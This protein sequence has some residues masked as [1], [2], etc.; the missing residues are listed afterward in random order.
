VGVLQA[1]SESV[2][3][4]VGEPYVGLTLQGGELHSQVRKLSGEV[5]GG[6]PVVSRST[7]AVRISI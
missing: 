1:V 5:L 3:A 6:V 2:V 7:H 4:L